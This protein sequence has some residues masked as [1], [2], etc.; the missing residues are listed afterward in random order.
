MYAKSF[1]AVILLTGVVCFGM[2]E[3][4]SVL[5]GAGIVQAQDGEADGQRYK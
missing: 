2:P 3:I 1:L 4:L 5:P